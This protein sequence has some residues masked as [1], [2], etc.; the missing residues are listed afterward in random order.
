MNDHE[1]N[2]ATLKV[3]VAWLGVWFGGVSLSSLVLTATLVYTLLQIFILLRR[4]WRG[5]A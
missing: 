4:L 2:M 5:K 1:T 3:L